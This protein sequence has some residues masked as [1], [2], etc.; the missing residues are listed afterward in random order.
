MQ[1]ERMTNK[2][3]HLED[4]QNWLNTAQNS[5]AQYAGVAQIALQLEGEQ[6]AGTQ[7]SILANAAYSQFQAEECYKQYFKQLQN[8]SLK[9]KG[10]LKAFSGLETQCATFGISAMKLLNSNF[11]SEL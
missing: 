4:I 6:A 9:D 10:C 8:C 2:S 5:V 11:K 3:Y 1:K 7:K